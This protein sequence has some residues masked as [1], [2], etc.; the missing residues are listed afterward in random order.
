MA[1]VLLISIVIIAIG[2]YGLV[3]AIKTETKC[4]FELMEMLLSRMNDTR[5]SGQAILELYFFSDP[6]YRTGFS[7]EREYEYFMFSHDLIDMIHPEK[8]YE[9]ENVLRMIRN[10]KKGSFLIP[11]EIRIKQHKSCIPPTD[12]ECK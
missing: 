7:Y 2:T 1:T 5:I 8:K 3:S 11:E 12:E 6:S 9:K 10:Y 4:G